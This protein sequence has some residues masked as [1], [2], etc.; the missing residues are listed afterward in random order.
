MQIKS[1][2]IGLILV[3]IILVL[4]FSAYGSEISVEMVVERQDA[5]VGE[6]IPM[7]IQVNGHNSPDKP[8]LSNIADFTVQFRGGRQNSSTSITNI[9]G[10]WSRISKH[11]FIFNYI[12]TPKRAGQLIFPPVSLTLDGKVYTTR[13]LTISAKEPEETDDFKLR[14][15]LSQGKCYVGE[16][17]TLT[18]TWYIGKDVKKFEFILPLLDDP[19]FE[20]VNSIPAPQGINSQDEFEI[21]LGDA[22]VIARR[23]KGQLDGKSYTTLIFQQIVIPR[24]NGDLTLPQATVGCLALSGYSRQR[25]RNRSGSFGKNDFFNDFFNQ[26]AQKIYETVITPSNKPRLTV[27]PLPEAGRPE[28]F[29]GPVGEFTISAQAAPTQ[30]NVGDPITLTLTVTGP[31]VNKVKLPDLH[32]LGETGFKIPEEISPGESTGQSK[33]FIQ[34]IRA[35]ND[36]VRE[37]PAIHLSYFNP[38]TKKYETARSSAITLSVQPTRIITAQDAE[39]A[40]QV[41]KRKI[42]SIEA[43][44]NF[45]YDDATVLVSQEAKQTSSVSTWLILAAPP[46]CFAVL[47]LS[48]FLMRRRKKNPAALRA[49]QA[50]AEFNK[51]LSSLEGSGEMTGLAM[52]IKTCLGH[53]LRRPPGALTFLDVEPLL[54]KRGLDS[55]TLKTLEGIFDQCE[56]CQYSGGTMAGEELHRLIQQTRAVAEKLEEKL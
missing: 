36:Q 7:Q 2:L 51:E 16:P 56:A 10:K 11:G 38:R 27:A 34:T 24:Q 30:V 39:G 21:T 48:S 53:K 23:S 32:H 1:T 25:Q 52:A 17:V 22:T 49:Q 50:F 18:T 31:L 13:P 40:A 47:F 35:R 26:G 4:N 54:R 8:S 45:N 33:T 14:L 6:A 28:N 9:N 5:F 3:N 41:M 37:I 42:K 19:R 29:N 46:G 15:N 44:I 20:V 55:E 43:G 12:L